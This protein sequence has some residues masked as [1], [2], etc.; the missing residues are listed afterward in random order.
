[1][2]VFVIPGAV[3]VQS[4]HH[5]SLLRDCLLDM[6]VHVCLCH[7]SRKGITLC[8]EIGASEAGICLW[9]MFFTAEFLPFQSLSDHT[10]KCGQNGFEMLPR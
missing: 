3:L 1:M 2:S 9:E 7:Y 10:E 6:V 4:T 5:P 8:W